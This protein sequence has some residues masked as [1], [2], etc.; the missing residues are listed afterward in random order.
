VI[1][2]LTHGEWRQTTLPGATSGYPIIVGADGNQLELRWNSISCGSNST[3]NGSS[4]IMWSDPSTHTSRVLLGPPLT[5]GVVTS[6]LPYAGGAGEDP[7]LP[8]W[9]VGY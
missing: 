1:V 3:A 6:V 7:G 9:T 8:Q 5:G 2:E 4:S